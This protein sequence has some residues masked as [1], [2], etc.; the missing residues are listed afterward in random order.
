MLAQFKAMIV[1]MLMAVNFGATQPAINIDKIDDVQEVACLSQAVHGEAGNQSMEGKIAVAYVIINRTKSDRF[2]SNDVCGVVRQ[3]G[4]FN[5][6]SHLKWIHE[7]KPEERKQ[8]V[9]SIKASLIAINGEKV[10]P[11]NGSLYFINPKTADRSWL[12]NLRFT[13]RIGDH[14]FYKPSRSDM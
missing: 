13:T 1:S 5:F 12:N 11:T 2:P 7:D 14:A 4:Q 9:D 8:M 6:L 10:D 3:K